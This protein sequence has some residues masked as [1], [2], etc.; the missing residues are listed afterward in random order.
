MKC[1]IFKTGIISYCTVLFH[2]ADSYVG[3]MLGHVTLRGFFSP[4]PLFPV[5][6]PEN[7]FLIWH[8]NIMFY[9]IRGH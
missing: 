9:Q 6:G 5:L 4:S 1:S 3:Y 2:S 8:D 7:W